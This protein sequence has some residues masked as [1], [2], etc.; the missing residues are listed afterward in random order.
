M[1]PTVITMSGLLHRGS[2]KRVDS[3]VWV[4]SSCDVLSCRSEVCLCVVCAL[5]AATES[6]FVSV[7]LCCCCWG[8]SLVIRCSREEELC[9]LM[10]SSHRVFLNFLCTCVG[11]RGNS[12][13]SLEHGSL[14]APS[15]EDHLTWAKMELSSPQHWEV[16]QNKNLF[17]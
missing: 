9:P 3:H 14:V 16:Q 11:A 8:F 2:R 7:A 4:W 6:V 1:Q 17:C 10:R 5:C 15:E 12:F 13:A